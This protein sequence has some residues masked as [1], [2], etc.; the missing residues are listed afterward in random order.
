MK[1]T[2][3]VAAADAEAPTTELV[4]LGRG[5][6]MSKFLVEDATPF[7]NNVPELSRILIEDTNVA[8]DTP[9]QDRQLT[10]ITMSLNDLSVTNIE[11]IFQQMVLSLPNIIDKSRAFIVE[12]IASNNMLGYT[13]GFSYFLGAFL[14][15]I[16]D[17]LVEERFLSELITDQALW[18]LMGWLW[19][20]AAGFAGPWMFPSTFSGGDPNL[21]CSSLDFFAMLAE[22]DLNLNINS[23]TRS[24]LFSRGCSA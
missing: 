8:A 12:D 18:F 23:I 19:F 20:Y 9:A 1:E 3:E 10:T 16:G 24:T 7:T 11:D 4:N 21:E 13:I 2:D 15:T 5:G 6:R 14:D 22:S 17:F